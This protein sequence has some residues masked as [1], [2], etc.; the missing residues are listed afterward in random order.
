LLTGW[1]GTLSKISKALFFEVLLL[2]FLDKGIR[3]LHRW[4]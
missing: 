1:L 3:W 2:V 4:T